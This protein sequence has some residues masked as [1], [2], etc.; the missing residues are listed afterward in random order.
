MTISNDALFHLR[1]RYMQ[2]ADHKM[3][4]LK[5]KAKMQSSSLAA[6]FSSLCQASPHSKE[7]ITNTHNQE[8]MVGNLKTC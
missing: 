4:P 2:P 1:L 8:E 7:N 6:G 3:K 5:L